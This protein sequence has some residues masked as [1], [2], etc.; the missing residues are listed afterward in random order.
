[1]RTG[2]YEDNIIVLEN[3]RTTVNSLLHKGHP[4]INQ[5]SM[6][7]RHFWWPW[8]T[9]AIQKQ[10]DNCVPCKKSG[11]NVKPNIPNTAKN[12]LPP[13]SKPNEE[14]Q[15]D[16]IGPITEKNHRFYILL[17]M[18]RTGLVIGRQPASVKQRKARQRSNFW[19]NI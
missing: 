12:Q 3:L 7:A 2:F 10:C 16:F 18:D 6:A 9:E 14:I 11:K 13:L 8:I 4:A 19:N 1:M 5:M 17:F 15:L